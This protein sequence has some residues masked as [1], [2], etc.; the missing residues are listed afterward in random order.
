MSRPTDLVATYL[1]FW[2][3]VSALLVGGYDLALA[4]PFGL[5]VMDVLGW[6]GVLLLTQAGYLPYYILA[7]RPAK[8]P[9]GGGR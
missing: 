6:V 3:L 5:P 7:R 2:V 9:P 8:R 1:G 4:H